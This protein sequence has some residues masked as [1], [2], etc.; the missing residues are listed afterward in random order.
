MFRTKSFW[1]DFGTSDICLF[2]TGH[3]ICLFFAKLFLY[4]H[5]MFIFTPDFFFDILKFGFWVVGAYDPTTQK[6]FPCEA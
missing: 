4:Q 5:R 2:Y 1:N 3:K 6:W